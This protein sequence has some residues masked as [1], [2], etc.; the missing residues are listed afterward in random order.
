MFS[1]VN[2]PRDWL[3]SLL[4]PTQPPTLSGIGTYRVDIATDH[5]V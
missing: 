1:Y 2:Q 4:R 3:R 5:S